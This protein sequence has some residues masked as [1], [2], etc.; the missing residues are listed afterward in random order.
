MIQHHLVYHFTSLD[1]GNT[2]YEANPQAAYS[3]VRSGKILQHVES[4]L[5]EYAAQVMEAIMFLGHTSITH[6]ETLP[7]LQPSQPLTNGVDHDEEQPETNGDHEQEA[8]EPNGN[9]VVSQKPARLHPTLKSLASHGYIHR[10][11]EAH[12]QSP[13]DNWLDAHRIISSRPDVKQMKGKQQQ[14]E[15]EEKAKSMVKE[16]TEGDLSRG[17]MFNGLPQGLKR[18]F[19]SASG[20][21]NAQNGTNGV[22]R[23]HAE[24]E[25]DDEGNDW[26][27]D[28]DGIDSS[29]MDVSICI[30][31][32]GI[33]QLTSHS[34]ISSFE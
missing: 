25:E 30:L 10:V 4:R 5:G 13:N 19:G 22:N 21:N 6:L 2:Y 20:S 24:D 27:E 34:L 12:F 14:A 11:R 16:R 18:K 15:I 8:V 23:D 33:Q 32:R 3:L 28:E 26:S 31:L 17:L 9:H 1:D 7:Q 29:P